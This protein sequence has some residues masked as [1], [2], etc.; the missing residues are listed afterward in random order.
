MDYRSDSRDTFPM[1]D[2]Q[3]AYWMS[4]TDYT[5]KNNSRIQYYCEYNLTELNLEKFKQSWD[6]V[7]ERHDMLSAVALN[8][9]Q[10]TIIKYP[11]EI[12]YIDIRDLKKDE[13]INYYISLRNEVSHKKFNCC[14]GPQYNIYLIEDDEFTKFILH[15][16]MWAIDAYSVNIILSDLA[17]FYFS[18]ENMANISYNYKSYL[19]DFYSKKEDV[20]D[21]EILDYWYSRLGHTS[22][23][24]NLPIKTIQNNKGQINNFSQLEKKLSN[25]DVDIL[26]KRAR[27][28]NTNIDILLLSI[29][30][31]VINYWND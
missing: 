29:F 3:T 30:C 10:Q 21:N 4:I 19:Q 24:P 8:N 25:K 12:H 31:E 18:E 23:P 14:E 15:L 16:N 22:F 6:K 5:Q 28:L 11:K 7:L 27:E 9:G 1:S 20:V 26:K 17:R 13:K 2:M